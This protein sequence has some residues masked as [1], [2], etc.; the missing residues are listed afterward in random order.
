MNEEIIEVFDNT[1]TGAKVI[2]VG[3]LIL[4]VFPLRITHIAVSHFL[5]LVSEFI[6]DI[7]L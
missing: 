7:E 3:I 4:L 2:V 1:F 6:S 5:D